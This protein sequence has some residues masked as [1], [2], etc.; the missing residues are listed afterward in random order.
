M[1]SLVALRLGTPVFFLLVWGVFLQSKIGPLLRRAFIGVL[2]ALAFTLLALAGQPWWV[3]LGVGCVG[4]VSLFAEYFLSTGAANSPRLLRVGLLVSVPAGWSIGLGHHVGDYYYGMVAL[5][6]AGALGLVE[7]SGPQK[8]R[9]FSW[10]TLAF[11][12]AVVGLLVFV[13]EAYWGNQSLYFFASLAALLGVLVI[14]KIRL[15][16]PGWIVQVMNTLILLL[17]GLC[18]ADVVWFREAHTQRT[19]TLTER[20]YSFDSFKRDP[21]AFARWLDYMNQQTKAMY[22]TM[23]NVASNGEIRFVLRSNVVVRLCDAEFRIN[24]FGFRGRDLQAEK[25]RTYRIVALGESTTFGITIDATSRPWCEWLEDMIRERLHPDRPVE[26]INAGIP[27][28]PLHYNLE[29]LREQILPLQPDLIISYHGYNQFYAIDGGL[30]PV[31]TRIPPPRYV[32]RP[33]ELLAQVE[34]RLRMNRYTRL[35]APSPTN[36]V[37]P[38]ADLMDT[39]YADDYRELIRICRERGVGVVL[40]TYS[41]AV[42]DRSDSE[43]RDFYHQ[44]VPSLQRQIRACAAH[45]ELVKRLAEKNPDVTLVDTQPAMDGQYDFFIDLVHFTGA[46]SQRMAETIFAGIKERLGRDLEQSP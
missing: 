13:G 46:G 43:V 41:M 6:V 21:A 28:V 17:P 34:Y 25:G 16:L 42:N 33:L 3:L 44:V 30:P 7:W 27:S 15:D 26:V 19:P 2:F 31:R 36:P 4:V 38:D 11:G 24:N 29:R 45:A 40:G 20:A 32:A 22:R 37:A 1:T 8:R 39:P 5:M 14:A 12:W 23:F 18:L 35:V 10:R 9:L